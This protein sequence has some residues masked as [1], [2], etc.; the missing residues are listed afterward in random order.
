DTS[1]RMWAL[2]HLGLALAGSGRYGEAISIFDEA[3]RFGQEYGIWPLL[4]RS[5]SM[6]AGMHLDLFD[7]AEN[8]RISEE[9]RELARSYFAPTVV[10]A[11]IDLLLSFARRGEVRRA[12]ERVNE[13]EVALENAAG[14][15]GWLWKLRLAEARAEI[16]LARGEW[17][18]ALHWAGETI[19][20]TRA[21]G[22]VKYEVI[23]LGTRAQALA[24]LGRDKDGTV[25][26]MA[27]LKLAR[28][29]SDPALLL[30]VSSLLLGID[31]D[32][33]LAA[34]AR[35]TVE[36]I[37]AALPDGAMRG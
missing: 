9:A 27:A 10:S 20:Q 34:E 1:A 35:A 18:A 5:I 16:A 23:A 22:R 29:V 28:R 14:W 8:E 7:Y 2:P 21:I 4:A 11:G 12:E 19:E 24:G 6:S 17:E 30:R 31:G 36:R 13:V 15:H 33:A 26:L 32:D 25:D 3:R 37:S